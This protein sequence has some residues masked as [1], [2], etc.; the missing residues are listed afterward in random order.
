M[1]LGLAR[2]GIRR[3]ALKAALVVF[4]TYAASI[5]LY[6]AF[7]LVGAMVSGPSVAAGE[8]AM[9]FVLVAG[10]LTFLAG[11]AGVFFGLGRVGVSTGTRWGLSLGYAAVAFGTFLFLAFVAAMALNR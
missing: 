6:F 9:A 7:L 2:V 11:M 3:G 5:V 4:G 1:V 8:H 10:G